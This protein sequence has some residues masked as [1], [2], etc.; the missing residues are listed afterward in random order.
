MANHQ[1]NASQ[2]HNEI[3]PVRMALLKKSTKNKCWQG[4]GEKGTLA[5]CW[6]VCKLVQPHM[7]NYIE[8]PQKTKN[9]TTIWSRNSTPGYT[10]K[11]NENINSK[12]YMHPYV[13]SSTIYKSQDVEAT[14]MSINRWM[15]KEDVVYI[16]NGILLSHIKEWNCVICNSVDGSRG[17]Y[18]VIT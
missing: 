3:S 14:Q 10:S 5:H 4:C 17:Y 15:D 18:A 7:E 13:H 12:R 9:R 11:E 1:R 8:F 2:N 16:H 6:W